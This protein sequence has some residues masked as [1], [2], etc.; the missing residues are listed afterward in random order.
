VSRHVGQAR[1]KDFNFRFGLVLKSPKEYG[2]NFAHTYPPFLEEAYRVL[3]PE[4]ILLCK[5]TDYDL[6][7]DRPGVGVEEGV[8]VLRLRGASAGVLVLSATRLATPFRVFFYDVVDHGHGRTVV[9]P[10][11]AEDGDPMRA[12]EIPA[13]SSVH[14]GLSRPGKGGSRA[15][16]PGSSDSPP[17]GTSR[18]VTPRRNVW[19]TI[20]VQ[21][22]IEARRRVRPRR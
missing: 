22:L 21:Y 20:S 5:I 18:T 9:A 13:L 19:I 15:S 14:G 6:G 16:R 12:N 2:Y 4:G 3:K 8:A 17:V 11:V 7:R 10:A 1:Q